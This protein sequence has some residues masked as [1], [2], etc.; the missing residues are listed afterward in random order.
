MLS[1]TEDCL[2]VFE[3][4][5]VIS[6]DQDDLLK[7]MS[8]IPKDFDLLYLGSGRQ[9]TDNLRHGFYF[10]KPFSVRSGAYSY[11][12]SR[13]GVEIILENLFPI[14]IARGGIDTLLGVLTMRKKIVTYH[15]VPSIC[16]V[17][18][19]FPSDIRNTSISG[20]KYYNN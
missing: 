3:D 7:I 14:K 9:P 13:K 6:V 20:K 19:L 16:N 10:T 8:V 12:L 4:D 2:L 18:A 5:I 1:S 11:V 15:L 17:N